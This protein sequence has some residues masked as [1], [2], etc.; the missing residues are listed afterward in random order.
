MI[1]DKTILSALILCMAFLLAPARAG[2][3]VIYRQ[4]TDLS[5][6]AGT[7]NDTSAFGNYATAYDNFQLP[8]RTEITGVD[9][10]GSYF[11]PASPAT[12][13]AFTVTFWSNASGQPGSTAL[14]TIVVSGV[15]GES[16]TGFGGVDAAGNPVFVY[17]ADIS[18]SQFIAAAGHTYWLSIVP[19]L[20]YPPQWG[21]ESGY[22]GDGVSYQDFFG[23][24]GQI[25]FDLAFGLTGTPLSNTVPEPGSLVLCVFCI[26]CFFC[27]RKFQTW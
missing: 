8:F 21:W 5:F 14:Q 20:D 3:D 9:W 13:T 15:A 25:D 17:N 1:C 6:V 24:R 23:S 10:T 26:V 16:S 12:I 4:T 2:A 7:Q 19:D 27:V 18:T 11:N 22:G